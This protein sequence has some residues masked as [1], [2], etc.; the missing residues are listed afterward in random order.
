MTKRHHID[1]LVS[2]LQ[3]CHYLC[4]KKLSQDFIQ[5]CYLLITETPIPEE[6]SNR[7]HENIGLKSYF[8]NSTGESSSTNT[9]FIMK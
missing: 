4:D 8:F 5:Y 3:S 1:E 9:F 6:Q 7:N 2:L